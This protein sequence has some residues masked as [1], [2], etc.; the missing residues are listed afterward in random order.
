MNVRNSI[1][2]SFGL[3]L[4]LGSLCTINRN[5]VDTPTASQVADGGAPLPPIPKGAGTLYTA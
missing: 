5:P 3:L 1:F 2:V 4:T